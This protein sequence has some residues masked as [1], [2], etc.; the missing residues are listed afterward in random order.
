MNNIN[1]SEENKK[2]MIAVGIAVAVIVVIF[3]AW[4]FGK[5]SV[6]QN[7]G[8]G[9]TPGAT[10]TS[11]VSDTR[12]SVSANMTVPGTTSTVPV[13]VAKPAIVTQ[14][15]PGTVSNFRSFTIQ[16]SGNKFS[17]D[18]VIANAGDTVHIN[19]TAVDKDYDFYQPD[20]GL[21]L[22]LPKGVAKVV[23]FQVTTPDK[24]TFYCKSCGG[25]ASGP[26]GY[27]TVVP[28]N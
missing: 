11:A 24:Y 16:V 8:A 5:N 2:I 6:S 9:T 27:V 23:E 15:A 20:Y 12:Q 17:P 4:Y 13:N 3:F 10:G 14:A 1:N 28:K 26:V 21:S 19:I 25:P 22:S 7:G 18:T